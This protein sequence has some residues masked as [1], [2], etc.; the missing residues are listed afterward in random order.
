[1]VRVGGALAAA[2]ATLVAAGCGTVGLPKGGNASAG[3]QLFVQK[4]GACHTLADAGTSGQI[5]P[6]L[7]NAFRQ[8]QADGIGQSTIQ[9]VVRDQIAYAIEHPS[10]GAPGMPRNLATGS[11]ADDV[12]VYV[13]SVAGLS[14]SGQTTGQA[15]TR[16]TT[17]SATTSTS[18]TTTGTT[19]GGAGPSGASLFASQGCGSC[20]MF[21]AAGATGTV[22]PDLDKVAADAQKAGTP[23]AA[24]VKQSIV[25]PSAYVVPGYSDGIMP[26][27]FGNT[28]SSQ[29]VAALVQ[30][31]SSGK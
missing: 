24:Y 28:L 13:A 18:T 2:L 30:F 19:G 27:T 9:A 25:D 1:V 21:K 29:Q 3:K 15:T 6:N 14:A 31:L 5:G 10:T 7:D 16:Q 17:T 26:K 12:A 22:G 11:D 8:S 4:C 20:H 23:L